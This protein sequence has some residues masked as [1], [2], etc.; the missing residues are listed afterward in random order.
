M[1]HTLARRALTVYDHLVIHGCASLLGVI[2]LFWGVLALIGLPWFPRRA[3]QRLGRRIVMAS[4]RFY[5]A[6]LAATRRFS[7]DIQVL[8]EL[9]GAGPMIIAPNHPCLLDALLVISRLP[10]VACVM[11]ASL[12]NN[13]F[14]G[15]GARFARFIR[16]KPVQRMVQEAI[17]DV[18]GGSQLLL[19][20]EG[21]RSVRDP[22]NPLTGAAALIA[23]RAKVPVQ[24]V[25]IETDSRYLSKG[26]GMFRVPPLPI[27]YRVILGRRFEP[28]SDTHAFMAELQRYFETE[29]VHGSAFYT[30]GS[31]RAPAARPLTIAR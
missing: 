27:H 14:L 17:D 8:D 7:F 10:N 24:T 23:Q 15:G 5:L 28:P 6:C 29:L 9:R 4:F 22:V 20:P 19:F 26:W 31:L 30:Q 21:T 1:M 18:R 2:C 25:L 16:N 13:L 3:A 12:M 11:K